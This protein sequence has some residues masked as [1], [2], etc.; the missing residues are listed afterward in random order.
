MNLLRHYRCR[1]KSGEFRL[2]CGIPVHGG[3]FFSPE[4]GRGFI[5]YLGPLF[6]SRGTRPVLGA[7]NGAVAR[8]APRGAGS[9]QL[10][11]G[12]ASSSILFAGTK[13]EVKDKG[14]HSPPGGGARLGKFTL[15]RWDW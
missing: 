7:A 10:V 12:R 13:A 15:C 6:Q 5:M 4:A 3:W 2:P 1:V 11:V 14:M 8:S 9:F